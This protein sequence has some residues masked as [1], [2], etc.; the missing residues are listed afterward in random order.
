M[1]TDHPKTSLDEL[2]KVE[3]HLNQGTAVSAWFG[4]RVYEPERGEDDEVVWHLRRNANPKLKNILTIGIY[5][6]HAFVIKDIA[7]LP[8]TYECGHC[9]ARFT[10]V[11]NLQR[12]FQTCSAGKTVIV[13]PGERVEAPQTAFE[14]AFYPKNTASKNSLLWL[15]REAKRRKIHIHH[16]MCGH[17]GERW[18]ER[19]LVDGYN[20]ATKTVFQYH[21]CHWHGCRKCFPHDRDKTIYRNDDTRE[22]RY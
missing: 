22:D 12:H 1:P 20:H 9:R 16:A 4:I 11:C 17:G 8:R 6:G 14:K 19:A 3:T 13:C 15:E 5:E 10:K 7:K 21:G 2:D 18:I